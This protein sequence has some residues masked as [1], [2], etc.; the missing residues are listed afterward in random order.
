LRSFADSADETVKK[1]G[2]SGSQ[3]GD[4]SGTL[5]ELKEA[6]RSIRNMADYL[7]SHP[8]SLLSGKSK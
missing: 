2:S 7:E 1:I 6:A 3:G 5:R 4:L 8:E